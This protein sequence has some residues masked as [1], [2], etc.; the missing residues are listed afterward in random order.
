MPV[1]LMPTMKTGPRDR[2][3]LDL[4][5]LLPF[6]GERRVVAERAGEAVD[7]VTEPLLSQRGFRRLQG[8]RELLE[9]GAHPCG[10][11]ALERDAE[12]LGVTPGLPDEAVEVQSAP[13]NRIGP[14]FPMPSDPVVGASLTN[15]E[16]RPLDRVRTV[17]PD[18]VIADAQRAAGLVLIEPVGR[19]MV[20]QHPLA[21]Q[22]RTLPERLARTPECLVGNAFPIDPEVGDLDVFVG[23]PGIAKVVDREAPAGV[24][25]DRHA[26]LAD[27]VDR[28]GV[29]LKGKAVGCLSDLYGRSEQAGRKIVRPGIPRAGEPHLRQAE[30]RDGH[31]RRLGEQHALLGHQL[32]PRIPDGA[33]R[34][35]ILHAGQ[36]GLRLVL[37]AAL[38][39]LPRK[40]AKVLGEDSHGGGVEQMLAAGPQA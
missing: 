37:D 1:R 23:R 4:G 9:S 8:L 36:I 14:A 33:E 2:Y 35:G 34:K 6:A 20:E 7:H 16:R 24:A 13:G 27:G 12:A 11:G 10:I 17:F 26:Y 28:L 29:P 22:R 38:T 21:P 5:I 15:Q 25:R 19:E 32:A 40:V 18:G 31:A 30:D 39:V 3:A